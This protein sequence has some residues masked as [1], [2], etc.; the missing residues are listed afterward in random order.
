M[1][2]FTIVAALVAGGV[3]L[4][5]CTVQPPAQVT[6]VQADG[7]EPGRAA[8][9]PAQ[10]WAACV[11]YALTTPGMG[12]DG[13]MHACDAEFWHAGGEGRP[14]LWCP[15]LPEAGGCHAAWGPQPEA[16]TPDA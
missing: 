11:T 12:G 5:G 6:I 13:D 7:T 4:S 16:T 2:K 8:P 14:W 1:R 10:R 15:G 9:S 3:A